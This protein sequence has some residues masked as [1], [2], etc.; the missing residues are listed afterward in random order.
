M[1]SSAFT[2]CMKQITACGS[3]LEIS[4]TSAIEATS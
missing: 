1:A 2:G 3:V 4:R